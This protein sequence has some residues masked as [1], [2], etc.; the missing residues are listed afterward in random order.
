MMSSTRRYW[1]TLT[2]VVVCMVG[3]AG[4]WLGGSAVAQ[5]QPSTPVQQ[6]QTVYLPLIASKPLQEIYLGVY[7]D[8]SAN[9]GTALQSFERT[10]E[11]KHGI[12]HY[13]TYWGAG[14]FNWH[15]YI[16]DQVTG[17]GA[18][19]MI[20]FMSIPGPGNTGCGDTAWNL[21][22]II[23]G[24][25]DAYLTAFAQ[26]A[27][28]YR[29]DILLRW[30]HEMNLVEYSWSGFC[31]GGDLAATEKFVEAYRHIVDI[32]RQNNADNVHWIWS[33]NYQSSPEEAWN[34]IE[35][36]YPGD[37]YVDWIGVIG[38]NFGA[39]R[40]ESG[41]QWM[42]FDALFT[43]F[44]NNAAALHPA[45]PVMLADYASTEA[46]GGNKAEWITDA[47]EKM[48]DHPNLRAVVWFHKDP[49]EYSPPMKFAIDSST[50][51]KAAYQSAIQ[52]PAFISDA[53]YE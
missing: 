31:N 34:A 19:P 20:S 10:F 30:G 1:I 48:K 2:I 53:P 15:K 43:A 3:A 22:S 26:Q 29:H 46:D 21:D 9:T 8:P 27:S 4:S 51:S 33:P 23:S 44:L 18:T 52:D 41:F 47:F 45:K 32:F 5:G 42:M 37:N 6:D 49:P 14:D 24:S 16:L 25:H 7:F 38:Y 39:S 50:A 12:Y 36:Y 28:R 17:Y 35:N 40:I 13:Y 11:K